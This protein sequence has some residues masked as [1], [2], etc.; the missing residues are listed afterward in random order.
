MKSVLQILRSKAIQRVFSVSPSTPLLEAAK[1][2]AAKNVGALVVAD[3]GQVVGIVSER[4]YVR[5]MAAT[6]LPPEGPVSELMTTPVQSVS[7]NETNEDCM[8]LMTHRR[9]RH[10]LV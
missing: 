10:L 4:D 5:R 9:L 2:M 6:G 1:V 7:V 8:E 3:A